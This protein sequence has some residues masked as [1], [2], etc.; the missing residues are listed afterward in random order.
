MYHLVLVISCDLKTIRCEQK[1]I[2][3]QQHRKNV[4]ATQF[5]TNCLSF[6]SILFSFAKIHFIYVDWISGVYKFKGYTNC[7][8]I[9]VSLSFRDSP[10]SL[11]KR[12]QLQY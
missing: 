7:G 11:E 6:I 12:M 4:Q 5:G 2:Y 1:F 10:R 8:T 9:F 3:I